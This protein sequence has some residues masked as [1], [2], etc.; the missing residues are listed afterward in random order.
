MISSS[1]SSRVLSR[2]LRLAASAS[3]RR[4]FQSSSRRCEKF[5]NADPQTFENAIAADRSEGKLVL[6]DFYADW[7]GPCKQLSPILEKLADDP[8]V[9]TGS[10][11]SVDLVTIDVDQEYELAA[12]FKVS[13]IPLVVAFKDGEEVAKFSGAIPET[14]VR[15]FLS[16]L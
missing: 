2:S 1:V 10:G 7:C 12:D 8:S 11:R 16:D 15:K 4:G 13:S 5:L 14:L 9:Q 6:I 3:C